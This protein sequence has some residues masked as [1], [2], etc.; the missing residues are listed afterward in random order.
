MGAFDSQEAFEQE[1]SA[2]TGTPLAAIVS[3]RLSND[4]Y[5]LPKI[6]TAYTWWKKSRER[7]LAE[8]AT[9]YTPPNYTDAA[10]GSGVVPA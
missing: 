10:I 1:Y 8:L 2:Y 7:L 6:S 4:S 9:A 5:G 3:A